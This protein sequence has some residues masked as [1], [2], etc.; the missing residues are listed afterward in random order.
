MAKM[1]GAEALGERPTPRPSGGL[2]RYQADPGTGE[3]PGRAMM[4][5]GA[6]LEAEG[7]KLYAQFKVE[8]E[9]ADKLRVQ[10]AINQLRTKAL[11]LEVGETEGYRRLQGAAAVTKGLLPEYER[12]Y[13]DSVN[14]IKGGLSNDRQREMFLSHQTPIGLSLKEGVVRHQM[15]QGEVYAKQVFEGTVK[16]AID[17][18]VANFDNPLI[19]QLAL[20]SIAQSTNDLAERGNWP[21]ELRDATFNDQAG[22]VH[23]AVIGQALA[24]GNTAYAEKWFNEHKKSGQIDTQTAS[25]LEVAVRD[26]EQ[27]QIANGYR[28]DF[29]EI[30]QTR[31][32]RAL[33]ALKTR[34]LGDP[35]LGEDR[36]NALVAQIQNEENRVEAR[37]QAERAR[38]ERQVERRIDAF[39]ANT[40]AGFPPTDPKAALDLV[41]ATKGTPMQ[42]EAQQALALAR[43][44]QAFAEQPPTVQA[45]MLTQAEAAIRK[46]PSK[47]DRR[48]L[49]A[50]RSISTKQAEDAKTNP[51]GLAAR[52]GLVELQ[53]LDLANPTA[54][55]PALQQRFDVAGQV[56]ARY[57]VPV[58]P[59]QPEEVQAL[60]FALQKQSPENQAVYLGNLKKA[61]G[62]NNQGYMATMGQ[63]ASDQPVVAW[64]GSMAGR[65]QGHVAS[66]ILRGNRALNP[67]PASDGKPARGD[68]VT[69]PPPQE[70]DREFR[71][72]VGDAFAGKAESRSAAIQAVRAYYAAMA[73]DKPGNADNGVINMD[74]FTTAVEKVLGGVTTYNSRQVVMPYGAAKGD[75]EDG[76]KRLLQWRFDSG[77]KSDYTMDRLLGLPMRNVGDGRYV[78]MAGDSVVTDKAGK[79]IVVDFT[80]GT[81]WQVGGRPPSTTDGKPLRARKPESL[82]KP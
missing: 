36:R 49:D 73:I 74:F 16:T 52:Q 38:W 70:F 61:W 41:N 7:D 68:L 25:R 8:E 33:G 71:K 78:F 54:T 37:Q 3:E 19:V 51:V 57:G 55:G 27:K 69:M 50:W 26:G 15:Q 12:K 44:T 23:A 11:D 62:P 42:G 4:R 82:V 40:F 53:P 77:L 64:A 67:P 31:S 79:D 35:K 72:T 20:E 2:A 75:F 80:G 48:V 47:I 5:L 21:K 58:K 17:T 24:T 6:G 65:D 81:P 14:L 28:S 30:Q 59:L 43:A 66:M 63:L 39:N 22:K 60:G 18:S 56:S 9:R 46:D 13:Q 10:D 45:T 34:V 1:P 32:L 76:V 29:L